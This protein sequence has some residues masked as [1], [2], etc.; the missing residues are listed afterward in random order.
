M[1]IYDGVFGV[2][3]P[4]LNEFV[5]SVY[6]AT[7]DVLLRDSVPV[8]VPPLGVTRIEYDIASAPTV[9]L[10]PSALVRDLHRSLLAELDGH[11]EARMLAA[12]EAASQASFELHAPS[13]VVVVHYGAGVPTTQLD[14]SL[15][16][17]LQLNLTTGAMLTPDIVTMIVDIPDNPD[18]AELV[19]LGLVPELTRLIEETFLR[20]I[21][22]PPL[23]L[24]SLQVAP[25]VVVTGGGRLLA[26]TAVLPA[27]PEP[28]PL[29]GAWPDHTVFVAVQP[30]VINKL[31]GDAA[32]TQQF[33]GHWDKQFKFLFISF[34]LNADYQVTVSD[35]ALD[36]VPGQ[37]GQLRGTALL[38]LDVGF[39]AKNLFSF[40]ATGTARPTVRVTASVNAVNE[41][42]VKL[43]RIEAI[44]FDLDFAGVPAALDDVIEGIA[45]ALAP[46]VLNT[47]NGE[48][49]KVPPQTVTKIPEIPIVLDEATVV[50]TLKDLDITTLTTPDGKTCLAATGGAAVHVQPQQL[51]H[52]A[53][54]GDQ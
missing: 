23:G 13:L 44:K 53:H 4:T 45:N 42:V 48:L 50:V 7:H 51:V 8:S 52:T 35:V 19:N 6:D 54:Q 39:W 28:A 26:T 1:A 38:N 14:A 29:A 49:A 24:G 47:V 30:S 2:D 32:S 18:L 43:D 36:V 20:P 10:A 37:D 15:R 41:V 31:V 3:E 22:I 40:S 46:M 25:P 17:G 34:T 27:Q 16:A 11:D 21:Q 9:S 33:K 12:A 5:R